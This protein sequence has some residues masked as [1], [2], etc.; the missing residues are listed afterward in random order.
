MLADLHTCAHYDACVI[1]LTSF[2]LYTGSLVYCTFI[3]D[4]LDAHK[5]KNKPNHIHDRIPVSTQLKPNK[6]QFQIQ[7]FCDLQLFSLS[8][9]DFLLILTM[10]Q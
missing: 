10:I 4:S 3:P 6:W 2:H 9:I 1:P 7:D 8:S 5:I